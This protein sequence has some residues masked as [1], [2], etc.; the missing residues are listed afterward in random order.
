MARL[1]GSFGVLALLLAGDRVVRAI[2]EPLVAR[3]T[4]EMGV[5]LALGA[6][7]AAVSWVVLRDS[8]RTI[9]GVPAAGFVLWF[10]LLRLTLC[11]PDGFGLDHPGMLATGAGLLLGVGV[12]AALLP[13]IRAARIDPIAAIRAE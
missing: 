1:A 10:P 5:R 13:A 9:A 11:L 12:I 8:L 3:R 7:P 2:L 4:N 6:S